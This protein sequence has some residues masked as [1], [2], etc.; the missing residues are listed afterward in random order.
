[1]LE[2]A[3]ISALKLNLLTSLPEGLFK[4]LNNLQSVYAS[5]I[6]FEIDIC[7]NLG[8]VFSLIIS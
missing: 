4:G 6:V 8:L 3:W 5:F 7:S 1:M 2:N